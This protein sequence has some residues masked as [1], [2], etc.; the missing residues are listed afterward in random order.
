MT[1]NVTI[2]GD[3]RAFDTYFTNS[4]Y[5]VRYGYERTFPHIWRKLA[6]LDQSSDYDVVHIPDHFRGGTVQNNIIRL[7]LT[8]PAVVVVLDGIWDTLISKKHFLEYAERK[9]RNHPKANDQVLEIDYSDAILARL[10]VAGELSVSPENFSAR[11]RRIVSYFRRRQRQ[12]IWMTLPVPPKRYVGSNYHAGDYQPNTNWDE[13]LKAANEAIKPI[14][15]A[16]GGLVLDMT[17]EMNAVGG[18]EQAF[19]DQ[20][21]FTPAFHAHI[22]EALHRRTALLLPD[23]P[24]AGHISHDYMLASPDGSQPQDVVLYEGAPEKEL[25]ALLSLGSEQIMIYPSELGQIDN[26]TGNDRAEFEKQSAS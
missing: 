5:A 25:D 21:H 26:P 1:E 17:A 10:F 6:L 22:A 16:Y 8:N 15:E 20:W 2:L 13:C 4:H 23:A 19:I 9:L 12:V 24:G 14:V 11:S 18:A 3:S 7:A